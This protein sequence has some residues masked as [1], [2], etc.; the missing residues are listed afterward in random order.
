MAVTTLAYR[1]QVR[2]LEARRDKLMEQA[3][4]AKMDLAKVRTELRATKQRGAK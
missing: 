1:R 3:E 2:A 4:K